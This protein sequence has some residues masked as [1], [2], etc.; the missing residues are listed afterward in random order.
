MFKRVIFINSPKIR[1]LFHSKYN[2]GFLNHISIKEIKN[3][4]ENDLLYLLPN[5]KKFKPKCK[6]K[7]KCKPKYKIN[8]EKK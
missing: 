3:D 5:F 2:D 7:S 6:S 4:K 8:S 1:C